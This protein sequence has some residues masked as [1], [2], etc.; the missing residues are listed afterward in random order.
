MALVAPAASAVDWRLEPTLEGSAIY[1][2][3]S[4]HSQTDPLDALILQAVPG[5]ILSAEGSRRLQATLQYELAGIT[6][7][8]FGKDDNADVLHRLNALGKAEL[9][10]DLLFVDASARISQELISLEGSLVEPE[11]N[12]GNRADVGTYMLS[13]YVE[14]RLGT[15]AN[16]QARYTASG[17]LFEN[18]GAATARDTTVNA[19]SA[20]LA[21]GTR[22]DVLEWGLNYFLRKADY[23]DQS[24]ST[25]ERAEV[26]LGYKLTRRFRIFGKVGEEWNDYPSASENDGTLWSAGFGWAP[27][28]RTSVEASA[29]E[30]FFGN[31]YHLSARHRTRASSWN[32]SYAEELTDVSSLMLS[33]GTVYDYLCPDEQGG[34]V[35]YTNWPFN[36]PP[37]PGCIAF[38]G[39]PGLLF[40]LRSGVFVSR[41]LRAGMSWGIGKL[42]YSLHA[43]DSRRD[44]QLADAEDRTQGVTAA[45]AYKVAPNTRATGTAGV[46]HITIPAALSINGV[47]RDDDL[48]TFTLGVEHQFDPELSGSLTYQHQRRDSNIVNGDFREN[49]ITAL[50]SMGF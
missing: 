44:F 25:L 5:F 20:G 37:L 47:D 9:V 10:E 45:V 3:N 34:F 16:A 26:S 31:T 29:G 42:N 35:L 2:D 46:N 43:F 7:L 30:R 17:A 23:D 11:I 15:F 1:T 18:T 50:V 21:N 48:Y 19:F 32:L 49:R 36:V 22:F 24:E 6:R 41:A 8:R 38:G 4:N 14:R 39:T 13:P 33:A 40:D 28:R 27:S 12:A